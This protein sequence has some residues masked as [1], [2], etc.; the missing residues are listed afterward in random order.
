MFG[1]GGLSNF[2]N[3]DFGSFARDFDDFGED[4][5]FSS[6]FSG[7]SN[8]LGGL[9]GNNGFGNQGT[10]ISKSYSSSVKFDENGRPQKE[11]Y[12]SQAVSHVDKNGKRIG[13]KQ[14]AY[15]NTK[16][17]EEKAAHERVIN[18]KGK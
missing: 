9:E 14:T 2:M 8:R 6:N 16:T 18:D 1:R 17:Q 11:T 5:F 12:S 13:E 7:M 3:R 10:V 4:D 15:Q